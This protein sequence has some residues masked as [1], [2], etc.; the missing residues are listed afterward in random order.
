MS[1]TAN[2]ILNGNGSKL[3]RRDG[4]ATRMHATTLSHNGV[5]LNLEYTAVGG[6]MP[7]TDT[8]AAEYPTCR[9]HVIKTMHGDDITAIVPE[10][11]VSELEER[12][13]REWV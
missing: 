4:T 10:L 8:D 7:A 2:E 9:I 1:S 11:L 13:E 6:F 12:V 3:L 5:E